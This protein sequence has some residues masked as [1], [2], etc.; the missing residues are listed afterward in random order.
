MYKSIVKALNPPAPRATRLWDCLLQVNKISEAS[1]S[2]FQ[3]LSSLMNLSILCLQSKLI[4]LSVFRFF[5]LS[6]MIDLLNPS[7]L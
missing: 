2:I 7:S 5:S 4:D 1:L 3:V 6:S